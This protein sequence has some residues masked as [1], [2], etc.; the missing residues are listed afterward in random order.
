MHHQLQLTAQEKLQAYFNLCDFTFNLLKNNLSKEEVERKFHRMRGNKLRM[1]Q[2][3]FEKISK[4][5]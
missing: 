3:V 2:V 4:R 1:Y 5:G